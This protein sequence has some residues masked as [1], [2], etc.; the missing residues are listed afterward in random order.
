METRLCGF[1]AF[2]YRPRNTSK[3][4]SSSYSRSRG[5]GVQ[6]DDEVLNRVRACGA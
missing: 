5:N 4:K 6:Y 3:R 1:D 2:I